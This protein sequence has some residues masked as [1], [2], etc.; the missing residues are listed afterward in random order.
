[1]QTCTFVALS[2]WQV[3]NSR[4]DNKIKSLR[5]M[6]KRKRVPRVEDNSPV[7]PAS[8]SSRVLVH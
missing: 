3:K 7:D 6:V 4:Q 8:K 5:P 2:G 1:M